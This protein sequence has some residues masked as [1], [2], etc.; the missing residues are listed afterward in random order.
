MEQDLEPHYSGIERLYEDEEYGEKGRYIVE[1]KDSKSKK[2]FWF[3][4]L[5]S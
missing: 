4:S 5:Q 2:K 3:L 1:T